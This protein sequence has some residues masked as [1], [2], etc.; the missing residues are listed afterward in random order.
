MLTTRDFI[1]K[2][3]SYG[4]ASLALAFLYILTLRG[5]ELFGVSMFLPP[6]LVGVVAS[7]E[8]TREG[9]IFG[10]VCGVLCDLALA[11]TFPCVYTVAFT[12][13]AFACSALSKSLLQPG[14]L[15]SIA[16]T[17]LTF[18]FV[19]ALNMLALFFTARA[20]FGAMLSVAVRETLVSCLLLIVC[21][22]VL[23][24]LHRKFTL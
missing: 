14:V 11:G 7:L 12:L 9:V 1:V 21:H 3:T 6:L 20:D 15:C 2:W 17:A 18:A 23:L 5:V 16:A 8:D 24:Y 19:D 4:A 22:P 13:A 10:L